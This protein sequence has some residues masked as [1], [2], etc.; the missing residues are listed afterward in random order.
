MKYLLDTHAFLWFFEDSAELSENAASIIEDGNV[1]KYVSV[2]S[3]WEFSIKYSIGKLSFDG[4]LSGIW[5]MI[6]QN[7]FIVLPIE[8]SH[9]ENIITNL[10]FHHR[11]PF[12]RLIIATATAEGMI[13]L[14][15]D[16]DIQKYDVLCAW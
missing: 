9:L 13:V 3:L 16:E 6:S 7:G 5:H 1:Q 12:D 14:T 2:A 15:A 4:G 8:Q 10:P 11:D